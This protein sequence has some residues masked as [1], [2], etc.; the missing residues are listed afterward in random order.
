MCRASLMFKYDNK[1]TSMTLLLLTSHDKLKKKH[2]DY[3]FAFLSFAVRNVALNKPAFQSST[4]HDNVASIAVD[5]KFDCCTFTHSTTE[6]NPYWAVDLGKRMHLDTVILTNRHD[7]CGK[8]TL[9][10][11][12]YAHHFTLFTL[13]KKLKKKFYPVF[14]IAKDTTSTTSFY[15]VFS[16]TMGINSWW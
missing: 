3:W 9:F 2:D 8:L 1:E 4:L 5:G 6:Q 10:N 14:F 12:H 15:R 11:L 7:C 16:I 13:L